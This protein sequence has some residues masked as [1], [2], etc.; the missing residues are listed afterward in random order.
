VIYFLSLLPATA[1]TIGGYLA[2][3]LAERSQAGMKTFGRFLGFW[4]FALAALVIL[5]A[6]FAAA[7]GGH[8]GFMCMH[9]GMHN[10]WPGDPP[11]PAPPP[12]GD[13]E[14]PRPPEGAVP[15]DTPAAPERPPR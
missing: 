5:G 15:P 3:F 14:R 1:L 13:G 8:R 11:F 2:W 7:H 6:I 10:P 12:R 9:P 4:A